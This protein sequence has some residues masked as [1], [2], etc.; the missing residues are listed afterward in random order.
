MIKQIT[1]LKIFII[2]WIILL[3]QRISFSQTNIEWDNKDCAL[4][5][6]F[7]NTDNLQINTLNKITYND[8]TKKRLKKVNWQPDWSDYKPSENTLGIIKN[9]VI[10]YRRY[11]RSLIAV[12]AKISR[13]NLKVLEK[14][15]LIKKIKP[16][17][18]FIRQRTDLIDRLPV[19]KTIE[20]EKYSGF[21]GNSFDQ[22]DQINIPD[23]H[24]EGF[25]GKGIRIAILDA[26][27]H[28]DHEAFLPILES[29]RLIDQYDF[30]FND[31]NVQDENQADSIGGNQ[32][33]HGTAVWSLIG[34][35]VPNKLIG[36]A[37][38]AEFLL[39][40]TEREGSETRVEE[41]NFV[42]AI[43]WADSKGADIIT[44]SLGYRDFDNYEYP[45]S[46]FDGNTTVTT[47]AANW[48]YTRG[49]L[50]V[51]AAGND[52]NNHHFPDGGLISPSD[53]WGVLTVGAVDKNGLISSFSSHG[54]TYDN[55]IKPDI[56][57]RGVSTFLASD[58]R[59]NAYRNSN[60]TS[61]STP[62]IAGGAALILQKYPDWTPGRVINEI[63]KYSDRNSEPDNFY[64]WGIPDFYSVIFSNIKEEY[65]NLSLKI[66]DIIPFPNPTNQAVRFYFIWNN[67]HYL[68][69]DR[70]EFQIYDIS[71][72]KVYSKNILQKPFGTE[73]Y[74]KWNLTN[75]KHY[76]L[77]SGIYF[78]LLNGKG[79]KNQGKIVILK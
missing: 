18:S 64:G 39:A 29:G 25:T 17:R 66:N 43:E 52:G 16:L 41:D 73:D 36:A 59:N 28:K 3:S 72:R 14:Q 21:Y 74:I 20:S 33:N 48:A 6:I 45:W 22:L 12:S 69:G 10:E 78:V 40:K 63:K 44:S 65:P 5:W 70:C 75:T 34:G 9:N 53:G 77:P 50:F 61:F 23:I 51:T 8:K 24:T 38:E 55:R 7:L 79:A 31:Y 30:I 68:P 19:N 62:L 15:I 54:P 42:A 60:G 37:Y 46:D 47:I 58:I 57:A 13:L 76:P 56:C 67:I 26:G 4:V 49:I 71:G 2:V 35:Y 11:S 27:F 1:L 32:S